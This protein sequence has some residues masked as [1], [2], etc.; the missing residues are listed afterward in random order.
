M[1]LNKVRRQPYQSL[2]RASLLSHT[3]YREENGTPKFTHKVARL[4]L[5]AEDQTQGLMSA[6]QNAVCIQNTRLHTQPWA[7][8][9]GPRVLSPSNYWALRPCPRW[10]LR[11]RF[12]PPPPLPAAEPRP[13]SAPPSL[14]PSL[15]IQILDAFDVVF[16]QRE[17][18]VVVVHGVHECL[19]HCRMI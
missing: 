4:T 5:L 3:L 13:P 7:G 2:M 16:I 1:S 17:A 15:T 8:F 11:F 19:R 10:I 12:F 6:L 14:C 9:P 18:L